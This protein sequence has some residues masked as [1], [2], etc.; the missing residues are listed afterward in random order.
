[1]K[2]IVIGLLALTVAL[3]TGSVT[4]SLAAEYSHSKEK[5]AQVMKLNDLKSSLRDLWVGHIFWVRNVALATK[6]GN[7]EEA[8]VAE[9]KVV[10]NAKA[11]AGAVSPFYGQAASDQLFGL[12]AGHYG[13]VKDYM[14]AAYANN[15]GGKDAALVKL[16]GNAGEIAKFLSGA[17]PYLPKETLMML[18]SGH[19][20][21]HVAQINAIAAKDYAE[22]A[23]VW[24]T[25]KDHIYVISDA[26]AT[27]LAKQFPK[28]IR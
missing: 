3:M 18:L 12:L 23:K 6:Y 25:M 24:D 17:N 5:A 13:A 15:Q 20:S 2:K 19:G 16:T 1:M 22:E 10:G 11:I 7:A 14:D 4:Q 27:G 8:K 21:H 28:K 9:G 26:L